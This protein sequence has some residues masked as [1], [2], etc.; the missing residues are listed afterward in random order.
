MRVI[1]IFVDLVP[2][3]LIFSPSLSFS[4]MLNVYSPQY[5]LRYSSLFSLLPSR[6]TSL[7]LFLPRVRTGIPK[8]RGLRK[9]LR[10]GSRIHAMF[11]HVSLPEPADTQTLLPGLKFGAAAR[12]DHHSPSAF[13]CVPLT[14][15]ILY[16]TCS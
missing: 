6:C 14:A 13:P 9:S 11:V 8:Y 16:I 3:C 12:P 15:T 7:L 1:K 5:I 2:N 4:G 10:L